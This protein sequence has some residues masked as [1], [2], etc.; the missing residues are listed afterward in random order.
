[1]IK[2]EDYGLEVTKGKELTSGLDVVKAE[3]E[4]LKEEFKVVS[5]LEITELNIPKFRELRLRVRD[6]R[7]KR[8]DKWKTSQKA[9]FLAGSNFVQAIY[10][11]EVLENKQMED[12]L[13]EGE[14]HIENLEKERVAKLQK[15]RVDLLS[16][17]VED[18]SERDLSSM[19]SDVWESYLSTKKQAHTDLVAA[20]LQAEKERVAKE[21][22]EQEAIKEQ[23]LENARLQAAAAKREKEFE[24]ERKVA[25]ME[26]DKRDR[27]RIE[28]M[29]FSRLENLSR[30]AEEKRVRDA[31]EAKLKFETEVYEAKIKKQ[32]DH[33][34]LLEAE[35]QASR[36]AKAKE[37]ADEKLRIE[38]E[39][40]KGDSAKVQDLIDDLNALKTK[41]S[42]ESSKN[43]KM[44]TDV[45]SLLGRVVLHINK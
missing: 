38:K 13:M 39:L 5:K 14:K 40:S 10:N 9:Y 28:E 20:E 36:D 22:A 15:E 6:N 35:L 25:K 33:K 2:A 30:L 23:A 18:A 41:Y 24:A 11:K 7:T 29:E 8:L 4:L 43:K 16:E 3:K 27:I 12:Y 21:K 44:Y 19:E 37:V 45:S 17:F 32:E 1:M 34:K 42:F 26:S 31:Q